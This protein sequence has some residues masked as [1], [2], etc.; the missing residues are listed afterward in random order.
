MN[1]K[2]LPGY[3]TITVY[4]TKLYYMCLPPANANIVNLIVWFTNIIFNEKLLFHAHDNLALL[5]FS[6]TNFNLIIKVIICHKKSRKHIYF[7]NCLC[8]DQV[9]N[10]LHLIM[11]H[12]E[13]CQ[14]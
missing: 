13:Y 14:Y 12:R 11:L 8:N 9:T 1:I 2:Q 5:V 7:F 6:F 10:S 3:H 4:T